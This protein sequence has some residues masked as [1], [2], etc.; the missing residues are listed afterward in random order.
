MI[1]I[2]AAIAAM[3]FALPANASDEMGDRFCLAQN[4]YFESANQ[5]FAGR[6][7]VANVVLNRVEDAQ[8]PDTICGVCLL[9]TSPSPRDS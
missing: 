7:A 6:V 9:Y 1:K 5:S 4:I 2:V 3:A 8:F